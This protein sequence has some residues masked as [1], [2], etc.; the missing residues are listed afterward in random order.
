LSFFQVSPSAEEVEAIAR[1]S[2]LYSK[3]ASGTRSFVA[4]VDMK[5]KFAT[6][7][8]RE[9]A[10]TWAI[11]PYRLLEQKRLEQSWM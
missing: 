11:E 1:G 4:D 5:Q 2:R 6:D 9:A 8:V 3:E 10:E 7:H